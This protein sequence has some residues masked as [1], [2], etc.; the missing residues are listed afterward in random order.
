MIWVGLLKYGFKQEAD[1]IKQ[2]VLELAE[3]HGFREYYNPYKG[4]G[5]GEKISRGVQH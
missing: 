5:L 4:K 1:L 2:G 3:N